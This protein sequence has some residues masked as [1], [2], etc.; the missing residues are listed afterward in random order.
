[1]VQTGQPFTEAPT[2]SL[3]RS[4][5]SGGYV[6]FRP[7][8]TGGIHPISVDATL[9][10]NVSGSVL[11]SFTL[12]QPT[13]LLARI[14]DAGP[15]TGLFVGIGRTFFVVQTPGLYAF[16][17]RLTRAGT[18]SANCLVR[19]ASSHHQ[20]LRNVVLN[21]AGDAV[22]NFPATEFRL[23][24]GLFLLQVAAGCWRGDHMVGPGEM[25]V[26]VRHPGESVMKP[27]MADEITRP[28]PLGANETPGP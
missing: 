11:G 4:D 24:P 5:A 1:V 22:L 2:A 20:M 19:L 15:P 9:E 25:T 3:P 13:V 6:G 23:E 14:L 17:A 21:S 27:A 7:G 26:M 28:V 16:S 12:D 10:V 8:W 18:Q